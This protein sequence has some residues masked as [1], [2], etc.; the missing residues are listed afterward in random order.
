MKIALAVAL[1]GFFM[2]LGIMSVSAQ[3]FDPCDLDPTSLACVIFG[4]GGG[5][6]STTTT[7]AQSYYWASWGGAGECSDADPRYIRYL[8]WTADGSYVLPT[9][10]A[11]PPNGSILGT[12]RIYQLTCASIP[13]PEVW[14]VLETASE[15]LPPPA[16]EA[17]PPGQGVTGFEFWMWFSGQTQLGPVALSWTDP[18]TGIAFNLQGRAWVGDITWATGDGE[19]PTVYALSY[20]AGADVGGT[21]ED[22][23]ITHF[24]EVTSSGSGFDAGYP[25]QIEITWVGEWRWRESGGAWNPYQPMLNT[26]TF[27]TN[28]TYE[29]VQI[30]SVLQP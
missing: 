4:G 9:E 28:D 25:V 16:W 18:V 30:V 13:T 21:S 17:S 12:D 11:N 20:A 26:A 15:A 3:A 1:V 7:Q 5:G 10:L 8:R 29:V 24:Y 2:S 6:G 14:N 22:P 27:T 23:A 19:D